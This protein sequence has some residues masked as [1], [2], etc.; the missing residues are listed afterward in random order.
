M[1]IQNIRMLAVADMN[2]L[3]AEIYELAFALLG[4]LGY[5]GIV[6]LASAA[7]RS[8][9]LALLLSLA[10]IYAPLKLINYCPLILQ[11]ALELIPLVGSS[12]DIFRT[13]TFHI[14][15]HYLWSPYLLISVPVLIGILCIPFAVKGWIRRLRV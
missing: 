8:N 12:M 10:V 9:V 5:A 15:G 1:P 6:M 4:A 7:V 11:K 3:Q 13:N 2:M 14:L